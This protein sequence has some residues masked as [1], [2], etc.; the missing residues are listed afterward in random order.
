MEEISTGEKMLN[1]IKKNP[2]SRIYS[3][4]DFPNSALI[5]VFEKHFHAWKWREG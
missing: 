1:Y 5:P 2:K 4:S 3:I